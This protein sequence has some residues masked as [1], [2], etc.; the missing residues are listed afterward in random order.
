MTPLIKN[1]E[2]AQVIDLASLVSYQPGQVV[3]RTFAQNSALSLTLFALA[4]GEGISAHTVTADAMVLVL[5]GQARITIGEQSLLVGPGQVVVMPSGVPHALD[6][7]L[8]F[9]ML[10]TVVKGPQPLAAGLGD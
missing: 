7:D 4:Q 5:D 10:L 2:P 8:A 6:A 9:K 3:S 1:L